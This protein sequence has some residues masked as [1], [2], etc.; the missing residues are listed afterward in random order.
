MKK[1]CLMGLL[2][3]TTSF[4]LAQTK[5]DNIINAKEVERIEKVL[6]SDDMHGRKAFTPDIDKA[7]DLIAAEFKKVELQTFNNSNI[8]KQE[9]AMVQPRLISVSVTLDGKPVSEKNILIITCQPELK[10]DQN[11]GYEIA[12]INAGGSLSRQASSFTQANKN[13]VVMVDESYVA[14]FSRLA[15][16]KRSIFKT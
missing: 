13:V 4:L 11:S 5:I 1:F 16:L 7:A 12:T 8:Y 6:A 15:F 14:N 3:F 2:L 9:F 10:I